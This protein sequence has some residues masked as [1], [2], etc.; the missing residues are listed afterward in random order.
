MQVK[1]NELSNSADQF[2]TLK[3]QL[4]NNAEVLEHIIAKYRDL[5]T[6]NRYISQIYTVRNEIFE[7]REHCEQFRTA[8]DSIR[9]L[10]EASERRIVD[11]CEGVK[12]TSVKVDVTVADLTNV[13][14]AVSGVMQGT[15]ATEVFDIEEMHKASLEGMSAIK[16]I[17]ASLGFVGDFSEIYE[18]FGGENKFIE[19][20]GEYSEEI[21]K[22]DVLKSVGYVADSFNLIDALNN[23]DADKVEKLLVKYGEKGIGKLLKSTL[24]LDGFTGALYISI[25]LN[26]G[27]NLVEE[28]TEFQADPSLGSFA[29][30]IWGASGGALFDVS[31]DIAKDAMDLVVTLTGNEFN[32]EGFDMAMDYLSDEI[33]MVV[34]SVGDG[35]EDGIKY[36]GDTITGF[37]DSAWD[38]ICNAGETIA[39]WLQW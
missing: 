3:I 32:E 9:N 13:S 14:A 8:L 23:G 34:E 16:D 1:L 10:Y 29:G 24:G 37:V 12:T 27:K 26:A 5:T 19:L 31:A 18:L 25:G 17:E 6:F 33:E 7:E 21:K 38:G 2:R 15:G 36:V 30:I 22:L 28:I 35:I 11:R 20:L 4:D 39:S